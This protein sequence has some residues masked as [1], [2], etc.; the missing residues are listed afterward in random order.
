MLRLFGRFTGAVL[1]VGAA[2]CVTVVAAPGADQVRLTQNPADV[3][4]CTALGNIKLT[5]QD[6]GTVA[7]VNFRNAVVRDGGNTGFITQMSVGTTDPI[8]G[9]AYRC[10][11][12]NAPPAK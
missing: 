11:S 4:A 3:S 10:Q 8:E 7:D 1:L 6:Q 12:G 9:I 5:P 2:G